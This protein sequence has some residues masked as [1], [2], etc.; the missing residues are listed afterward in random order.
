MWWSEEEKASVQLVLCGV[1]KRRRHWS[2][3][4]CVVEGRGE[5]IGP[6][7]YV[8]WSEEEKALVQLVLCGGVKRRRHQS[9]LFCVVEWRGEGIGPTLLCVMMEWQNDVRPVLF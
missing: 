2:N 5:G 9:N 4:F 7:C 8:W 3:L 6:T 1:V